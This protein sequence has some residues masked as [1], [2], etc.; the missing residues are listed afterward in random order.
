M[1]ATKFPHLTNLK[2][3]LFP[4]TLRGQLGWPPPIKEDGLYQ[5]AR[6]GLYVKLERIVLQVDSGAE[7][8]QDSTH[9]QADNECKKSRKI[10]LKYR[11]TWALNSYWVVQCYQDPGVRHYEQLTFLT[12]SIVEWLYQITGR[13]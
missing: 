4:V 13:L 10:L 1:T 11:P 7:A 8:T 12:F 6:T 3:P 2:K 5:V 9:A